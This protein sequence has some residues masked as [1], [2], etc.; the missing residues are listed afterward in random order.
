MFNGIA[1]LRAYFALFTGKRTTTS[2]SLRKT[3]VERVGI[4]VITL[5]VF[6][7]GWFSPG[8]VASRHETADKLLERT[9]K[10]AAPASRH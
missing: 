5:V 8:V 1:I 9:G 6:L 7:G 4:I 2:V 3:P 10:P